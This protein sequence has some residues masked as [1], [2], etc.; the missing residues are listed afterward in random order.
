M[1]DHAFLQTNMTHFLNGNDEVVHSTS[2]PFTALLVQRPGEIYDPPWQIQDASDGTEN[3]FYVNDAL[4]QRIAELR[5]DPWCSN[6]EKLE[7]AFIADD[8]AF[9]Q[10]YR[11]MESNAR[12]IAA[13]PDFEEALEEIRDRADH[14][15][16]TEAEFSIEVQTANLKAILKIT[17][18]ALAKVNVPR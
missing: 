1:T 17:T 3:I 7:G 10:E 13:A 16:N 12:I 8:E 5:R 4:G 14:L 15:L 2:F 18:E 6:E 9:I 11:D